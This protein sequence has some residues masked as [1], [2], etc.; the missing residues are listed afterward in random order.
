MERRNGYLVVDEKGQVRLASEGARLALSAGQVP[1]HWEIPLDDG[2]TLWILGKKE[3][4]ISRAN[5]ALEEA[6]R[7]AEAANR[8]KSSFL[9]N[10]SHD[11]RTPMNAILGMTT[12]A[13]A[14]VDERARVQDC[15][16]K[17]QSASRHLMSLVN[18]V[19][20][21]SRIDSG[22]MQIVEEEFL[23]SDLVHDIDVIIRPQAEAKKQELSVQ[24]GEILQELLIG[25]PL[26]LRQVFVNILGNAVKYTLEEGKIRV[27]ISQAPGSG[28]KET[29]LQFVCR[30]S[31]V[32]MTPE[33][34]E[35]IF[36]PF[37]R[38]KDMEDKAEGTGL[39][40]TITKRLV[41]QMHGS[42][43]VESTLGAGSTFTVKL[44][45]AAGRQQA[46]QDPALA[47]KQVLIVDE[48][49]EESGQIGKILSA[50]GMVCTRLD[51][52]VQAVEW[53]AAAQ[54][55]GTLPGAAI[56]GCRKF[57]AVE[58]ELAS[59]L[60]QQTEN[61]LPLVLLSQTDWSKIEYQATRAGFS[62]FVPCPLFPSR[63]IGTMSRLTGAEKESSP[64]AE[65]TLSFA[66][67]RLLLVEDNEINRE[68]AMEL[69]G[70][71]GVAMDTAADGAEAV[72]AFADSAPGTYSLILMD[73]QMP[74]MDGYAAT[75]AI[76]AMARS[77]AGTVPIVAMTANAFAEDIKRSRA[78][79]MNDHLSKPINMD[80]VREILTRYL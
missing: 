8:A 34:L 68:I 23:L 66:G 35:R 39:G 3:D 77:D 59:Y 32:G 19:L 63:L 55:G 31:G 38:A 67:K 14:H 41:D 51:S 22:R 4:E 79:G 57:T 26:H 73:V 27:S 20:D 1:Q 64:Q 36:E 70:T 33:F 76:R 47:G 75:A 69:I 65:Q 30:D 21:M 58:L 15:L 7:S 5:L 16:L 10:M 53:L 62:A 40:M 54:C 2:H 13:L 56:L 25:D 37:E 80:R 52:G 17:I 72:K 28:E 78:A 12:I 11:I 45:L 18:D 9:S 6:L 29:V 48:D 44:P 60:R 42:I 46:N 61:K 24:I 49:P 74:V 50:C 43:E 71:S